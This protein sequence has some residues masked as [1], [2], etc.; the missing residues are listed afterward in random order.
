MKNGQSDGDEMN[1]DFCGGGLASRSVG[2]PSR[3]KRGACGVNNLTVKV[4]EL[5]LTNATTIL[6]RIKMLRLQR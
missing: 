3:K 6:I 4:F 2:L 5:E 1:D